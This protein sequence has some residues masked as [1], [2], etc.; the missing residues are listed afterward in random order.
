MPVV[1]IKTSFHQPVYNAK[2][3]VIQTLFLQCFD[4]AGWQKEGYHAG[5]NLRVI[6]KLQSSILWD[7]TQLL[8]PWLYVQLLH[9]T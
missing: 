3:T 7:K 2:N 9:A 8:K 1:H 4:T 6:C 5:K